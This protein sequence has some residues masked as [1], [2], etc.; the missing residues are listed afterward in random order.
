[1][2]VDIFTQFKYEGL[3]VFTLNF[4]WGEVSK[5][6]LFSIEEE[7]LIFDRGG[8]AYVVEFGHGLKTPVSIHVSIWCVV[9]C[10]VQWYI[11]M[12]IMGVLLGLENNYWMHEAFPISSCEY[13]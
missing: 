2:F 3:N 11:A 13:K 7:T 12:D 9:Y 6:T 8:Y 1:M 4:Y 10:I 5:V